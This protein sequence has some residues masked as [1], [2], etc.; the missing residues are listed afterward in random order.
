MGK[1]V[2]NLR[3]ISRVF[4]RVILSVVFA[5]IF[6]TGWMAVAITALKSG[7]NSIVLKTII[8]FAAP[9]VTATGFATGVAIFELFL[10]SRDKSKF[11]N[12]FKWSLIGCAIG[13]GAVVWFGPMLIV[14]GMFLFGT[15]SVAIREVVKLRKDKRNIFSDS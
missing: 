3:L 11:L 4:I 1:C 5:G 2:A 15:V 14:F 7:S 6:Y 10:V 13:A 9:V 8:W 12:I